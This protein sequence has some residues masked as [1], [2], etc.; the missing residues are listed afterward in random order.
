MTTRSLFFFS[1]DDQED[2]DDR[3]TQVVQANSS[4]ATPDQNEKRK[5]RF[6]SLPV[7]EQ[8]KIWQFLHL[9]NRFR[10]SDAFIHEQSRCLDHNLVTTGSGRDALQGNPEK[11]LMW[12]VNWNLIIACYWTGLWLM[13]K[14]IIACQGTGWTYIYARG[15]RG[16]G[17]GMNMFFSKNSSFLIL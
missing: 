17:G 3:V 13:V 11:V 16:G 5:R 1:Y 8:D 15:G 4:E 10:T 9:V 12:V 6:L 2:D 14:W 7:E